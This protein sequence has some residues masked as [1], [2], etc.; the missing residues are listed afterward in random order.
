MELFTGQFKYVLRRFIRTP[1]FAAVTLTTLAIGIGANTAI[2]TVVDAVLLKPL[3]YRQPDQLVGVWEKAPGLGFPELNASPSTY[4]TF[5][6]ENQ[7]FQ[8]IGLYRGDSVSVTGIAEPEQVD[9]LD[10]SD[11]TLNALKVQPFI[12][13]RFTHKDDSPGSPETVILAYGYWR[14]RFGGNPSVIGRRLVIDGKARDVIGVLPQTFTFMNMKPAL[15]LPF[16]LN[17]NEAFIGNFSY[18][19]L[20]RLKPGVTIAQANADVARMLPM[21]AQKF[22]PA[23]GLSMKVFEEARLGPNVRPLKQDVVGDIGKVLWVLMGTVGIVL[24]IACANVANLLLVR[25]EGRQRELAIRAALGAGWGRIARE[26]LFESV[27]LGVTGGALG[28]AVAY[29]ALRV[30][31]AIAPSNLPRLSEISIDPRVLL[32]TAAI[33]LLSGLLFGL[34]PVFK[35]AGPQLAN[36]LREGGRSLSDSKQRHR[37]RSTLVIV[38]VAL[39]LVLLISSGLMIRTFQALRSVQPG[40][41]QPSGLLTFSI[42]IPEAQVSDPVRVVR[43]YDAMRQK[44]AAIPGVRSVGLTNS[45]TMSGNN[46]NDPV[47]VEDRATADGKLPPIRRYKFI[48]PGLF[49]TMGN[50]LLAGRDYTWT[51][52]Y[53]ARPVLVVSE[54]FAKEYWH[55]PSAALGKRLR[56]SPK[57]KWREIIGV[58]GDERDD[59]VDKKAPEIVYWPMLI[60]DFWSFPVNVQRSLTF[61][62]RS[63]RTGS[64][65]FLDEVRHAVWS[66]NPD[67]PFADVSTVQQIYNKSMARTSFTLVMLA[68]A[69]GMALLLGL[70]GIYGVISYSV[71][72]RTREVGIR[73]ALG[74]GRDTVRTMFLRHG[75]V[76]AAVGVACGLAA[77]F[78]VT[79]LMSTLLF[80]VSPIDPITYCTVSVVLI[81][82][83][84]LASYLPAHKATGIDPMEALR[85]E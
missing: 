10:V 42:S 40:F 78:A 9:A 61:A 38:Q 53:E 76:L 81:G 21:M 72:Q 7:T 15:V 2:F 41:T 14:Q 73:M 11:G 35:Y 17:R 32:F 25:A 59:G 70:V 66:V 3:P 69:G 47:F 12:G 57:S 68:L 48:A 36:A 22:R 84:L 37:T 44:I 26:L 4:F 52:M 5:R 56:E 51:D 82:A 64:S 77:S 65:G 33:S 75:L 24:F 20:A 67:V 63:T 8:D 19:A 23:P 13:R 43:M 46:D 27:V 58:V 54:N 60:R 28:L 50:P 39:A 83:A 49:K 85:V 30:L 18:E 80:E 45:I 62:V 71:S 29:G 34:V 74:A 16:Q 79:R 31:V 6:E 55:T 1:L